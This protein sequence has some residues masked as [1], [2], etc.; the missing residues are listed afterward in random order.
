MPTLVFTVF[1]YPNK[2]SGVDSLGSVQTSTAPRLFKQEPM[3]YGGEVTTCE[4]Q[5]RVLR[6]SL[7]MV[8]SYS[9]CPREPSGRVS[10]G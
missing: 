10:L 3:D 1:G 2:A 7:G 8:P 5:A 4:I 6:L 9:C